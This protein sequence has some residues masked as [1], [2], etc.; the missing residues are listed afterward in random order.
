MQFE[1]FRKI[2]RSGPECWHMVLDISFYDFGF[3]K[4]FRSFQ[5]FYLQVSSISVSSFKVNSFCTILKY[6]RRFQCK[7]ENT[8]VRQS[9]HRPSAGTRRCERGTDGSCIWV[10]AVTLCIKVV[11]FAIGGKNQRRSRDNV[12]CFSAYKR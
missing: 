2:I 6:G 10:E 5:G 8:I 4:S 3:S 12:F 7:S 1:K 11:A 9:F